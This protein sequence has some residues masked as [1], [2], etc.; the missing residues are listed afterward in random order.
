MSDAILST[1][2]QNLNQ[3]YFKKIKVITARLPMKGEIYRMKKSLVLLTM[4]CLIFSQSAFADLSLSDLGFKQEELKVD[5]KITEMMETRHN[6]L[7]IH[8]KLGLV[9]MA[10]M[11][12]TVILGGTAKDNN[13]HKIAGITSGLLYWTTAYFSLSAPEVPGIKERGSTKIHEALAWIHAPL[14]AIVPVLG[15]IH[16]DNDNKGKPSSGLVKAHGALATAAYIS[17]MSAGLVMYFD[18]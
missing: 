13:A 14:M 9:T 1:T 18:F 12:A 16:K 7:Q 15:Y 2:K 11:T 5:P 8:Q 6:K 17:F 3:N 10:A 4:L